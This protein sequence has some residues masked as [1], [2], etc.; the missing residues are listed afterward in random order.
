MDGE[1]YINMIAEYIRNMPP[2]PTFKEA[3][4]HDVQQ[5]S[6]RHWAAG[7]LLE[8]FENAYSW[9]QMCMYSDPL[10]IIQDFVDE[11]QYYY[12]YTP[13]RNQAS[14]V[15]FIAMEEGKQI[16]SLFV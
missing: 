2:I 1:Y 4:I 5:G 7:I 14:L 6:Y 10:E 9:N 11:M 15:F 3:P 12:E 13:K 8:R 16:G